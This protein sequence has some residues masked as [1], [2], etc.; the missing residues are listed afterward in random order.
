[1]RLHKCRA[2]GPRPGA[3]ARDVRV[4][5]V[6]ETRL[7]GNRGRNVFIWRWPGRLGEIVKGELLNLVNGRRH[8]RFSLQ[9]PGVCVFV[10]GWRGGVAPA[11]RY[12]APESSVSP[13]RFQ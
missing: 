11:V 12:E 9:K 5:S 4:S 1:M 7:S 13:L 3:P 6:E 10:G 8:Q 2:R